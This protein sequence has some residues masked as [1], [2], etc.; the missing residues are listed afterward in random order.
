MQNN[1]IFEYVP[2][3]LVLDGF[4]N[5]IFNF[6][7]SEKQ[8]EKNYSIVFISDLY[9][10]VSNCNKPLIIDNVLV[11]RQYS[12]S[13][14]DLY[15]EITL[16]N[17]DK[18]HFIFENKT[19]TSHHSDQL[20]KH[21]EATESLKGEKYYF[22]LKTGYWFDC[23]INIP[24]QYKKLDIEK[25]ISLLAKLNIESDTFNMFI[26]HLKKKR[27]D[28]WDIL[29]IIDKKDIT[30][31]EKKRVFFTNQFGGYEIMRRIASLIPFHKTD[32]REG[33]SYGRPWTQ[34]DLF[35][36]K[37]VVNGENI[38]V[39]IFWRIDI[40]KN[41]GLDTPYISLRQHKNTKQGVE[42]YLSYLTNN[43]EIFQNVLKNYPEL[44]KGKLYLNAEM[45][46]EIGVLFFSGRNSISKIIELLPAIT[47]DIF[48][49]IM[50]SKNF[51]F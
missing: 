18:I 41:N 47:T 42:N 3:E 19:D 2:K 20:R 4:L 46:R 35:E 13:K 36:N 14:I 51:Y 17:G 40:R 29:R 43:R 37:L 27:D 31:E 9:N 6:F 25:L 39:S 28:I 48:N 45:E 50:E 10:E 21:I 5:W 44:E 22:Y 8:I 26:S 38:W 24:Q 23:D 1:N 49:Q 11:R 15:V 34:L 30:E 12:T 16:K 32:I 33:T 7:H